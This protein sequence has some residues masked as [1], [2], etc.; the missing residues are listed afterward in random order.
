MRDRGI[1]ETY[2]VERQNGL[3]KREDGELIFFRVKNCLTK[4]DKVL[5]DT[6]ESDVTKLKSLIVHFDTQ[7]DVFERLEANRIETECNLDEYLRI[8]ENK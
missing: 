2:Y 1:I 6:L 3:I 7:S 5:F 8:K 4:N